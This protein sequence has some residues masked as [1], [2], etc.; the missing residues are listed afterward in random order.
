MARLGTP[1]CLNGKFLLLFFI[2]LFLSVCFHRGFTQQ[3]VRGSVINQDTREPLIGAKVL[4]VPIEDEELTNP[5]GGMTDINGTFQF[6]SPVPP[7]FDLQ[8][9][10][11]GY[12]TLVHRVEELGAPIKLTLRESQLNL[13]AVEITASAFNERQRQSALSIESMSINAIKETPADNFYDGLGNLKGVDLT[14]AS[15]GFKIINTRGFN[16]TSPVRSLQIID[17]VDNQAPGLNFS[18]GNFLGASELDVEQV[19]LIVGASSAYYGPNAF[20]GVI[21]MTTKDPFIHQGLSAMVKAGERNLAQMAIR[22]AKS[23]RNKNGQEKFAFKLNA[24]YYRADDWVAGNLD[25]V[26]LADSLRVGVDNPGGYDAVNR[27]GDENLN[28]GPRTYTDPKGQLD[29]PG[30]RVF[31]RTGYREIDLVDY[32][33]RNL[34]LAGAFHYKLQPDLQLIFASNFGTGTTVYQ[35][36]NRYSLNNILFFQNRIELRKDDK[37]FIRAYA[38]HEDAGDSYDAVFTAFRIQENRKSDVDFTRDYRDYW[39]N[40]IVPRVEALPGF[41][42]SELVVDP[43]TGDI[44]LIYDF[45]LAN[46]IID[47]NQDLMQ[48][49]HDEARSV[50]DDRYL[51]PGTP[52]F[53]ALFNDI[54]SRPITEGRGT[55]LIDRSAL[56]HI[57][58]EYKFTPAFGDIIVGANARQYRPISEGSIFSDTLKISRRQQ[59]DGSVL[60]DTTRTTITNFEFG[61]YAGM[62]KVVD[63]WRFNATFRMDKNENFDLLF[64]PAASAVYTMNSNNIFRLSLASAIRNPTLADQFLFYNVGRAILLGN[65]SG[66]ERLAT[67]ES[68]INFS[69]AGLDPERLEYFDVAPIQPEKVRT[70]E[71]GYR[72]TWWQRMYIDAS[73]YYSLYTDFIGYNLGLSVR[74]DE[75]FALPRSVQ[76]YR[77]AANARDNVTTQGFAVGVNYYFPNGLALNGNYSWNR[78]NTD[79]DDPI[80]PAFNTPEHKFNLGISGRNMQIAGMENIGFNINYKWIEGF[81]FEGSPQ[82]TG[83]VP[84]YD[85]VDAQI[86]K[87]FPDLHSTLKI[88]AT[89]LLNNEQFHV[90][91]GPRV[92][93][94]AYVSWLVELDQF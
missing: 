55:R 21:S 91:G 24:F 16:S 54:T 57:H 56:Y 61:I 5:V 62:E 59:P 10:Y 4:L 77:I 25:E 50:A 14:A 6:I 70:I 38:T 30:L 28:P 13:D 65:L 66:F 27:Y 19:D 12:D 90:Y 71:I 17:G 52:E 42:E 32:D 68:F 60:S 9:T 82:F 64:S 79:S 80:I 11:I 83:F 26:D 86:N 18:L 51:E 85:M 72:G 89:N 45:D 44:E 35:G 3:T 36:D 74:F 84:T 67:P 29:Y 78:L 63:Q 46:Q 23:F 37:F 58:G 94:L 75:R 41:P 34:K 47:A 8:V 69:Q 20:N 7:P 49:W 88:G 43:V 1:I 73:Y 40:E 81:L 93:R 48:Q 87:F 22:Y 76:A 39:R 33:T 2:I 53:E 15:I 31:H 92:G